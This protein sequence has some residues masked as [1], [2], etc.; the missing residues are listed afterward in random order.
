MEKEELI[1]KLTEIFRD[2]LANDEIVISDGTTANDIEE[3][4]SL[5]HIQLIVEIQK[6]F[7]V[8]ITATEVNN[9]K[10]VGE[11]IDDLFKKTK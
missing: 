11:M 5:G 6:A 4:D 7:N 9:W 10:N 3:W 2:V 8:K 1:T